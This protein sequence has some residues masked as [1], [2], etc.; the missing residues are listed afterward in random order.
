MG[1]ITSYELE[2]KFDNTDM[3]DKF[4]KRFK[5][6]TGYEM[7]NLFHTSWSACDLDMKH[8][9]KEFK[10][11]LFTLEGTGEDADVKWVSYYLNGV[12]EQAKVTVVVSPCT[13]KEVKNE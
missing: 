5:E 1:Y 2:Y 8:L 7:D 6:V 9:S 3:R 11:V 13:L 12:E 4:E 10:D